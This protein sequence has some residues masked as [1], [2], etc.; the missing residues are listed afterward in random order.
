MFFFEDHRKRYRACP[1]SFLLGFDVLL[2]RFLLSCTDVRYSHLRIVVIC[3]LFV[4]IWA[5]M[6]DNFGP[7]ASVEQV[8][9]LLLYIIAFIGALYFVPFL[10]DLSHDFVVLLMLRFSFRFVL[11]LT[12]SRMLPSRRSLCEG[13]LFLF[14]ASTYFTNL[15]LVSISRSTEIF[16]LSSDF[17]SLIFWVLFFTL[18]VGDY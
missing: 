2:H 10:F 4:F 8:P 15:L 14:K 7:A 5:L 12:A 17:F 3:N 13:P 9:L 16:T 11:S 1:I 18:K 6:V